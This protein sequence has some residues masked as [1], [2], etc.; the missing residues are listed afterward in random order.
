MFSLRS[1][2]IYYV[3]VQNSLHLE[4]RKRRWPAALLSESAYTERPNQPLVEKEA[5]LHS[6]DVEDTQTH[7]QEEDRISI[8]QGS[9][10]EKTPLSVM[11]VFLLLF[12]FPGPTPLSFLL[13][14]YLP[15]SML[16]Y[17][18]SFPQN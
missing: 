11:A 10:N 9:R 13:R 5:P 3:D 15:Y 14:M 1:A 8:L 4:G 18:W 7:R 17:S 16:M 12:H 6:R 2:S